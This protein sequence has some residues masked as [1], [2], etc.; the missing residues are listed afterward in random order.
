MGEL[1]AKRRARLPDR[2]FAHIDAKGRR[3][4]P[5][6]DAAHV[7]SALSRF[8]QVAFEDDAARDRARLRLLSAAKK[9]GIVPIGF[10]TGQLRSE[11]YHAEKLAIEN[12]RL[13]GQVAARATEI[14]RLPTGPVTFLLADIEGSTALVARLGD[15][16]AA[17]LNEV[18][19]MVRR[20]LR[21]HAGSEVDVR[22]D[23]VF[24]VFAAAPDALAAA[25]GIQRS[26]GAHA[27]VD[28]MQVRVRIG[29]HSGEPT[30]TETG[31]VGLAVHTA[32]RICSA[33]HGGQIVLSVAARDAVGRLA[34][35]VSL[36]SLG[37]H[38]LHGLPEPEELF[39]VLAADLL[40]EFPPPRTLQL[41]QT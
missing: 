34:E 7:R 10:I 19:R 41:A 3:R 20:A 36:R 18:R 5:I 16:Y 1:D 30:L 8:N 4:L 32:A 39:Q 2:A 26:F 14:Q 17:L 15:R 22:A 33:G 11:R 29:L 6:N 37:A 25:V 21:Q 28:G 9:F 31:Y 38:Q 27:W 35:G 40:S 24:A 23:E 13:L 12:E